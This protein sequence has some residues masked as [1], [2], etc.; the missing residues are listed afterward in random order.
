MPSRLHRSVAVPPPPSQPDELEPVFIGLEPLEPRVYADAAPF[1]VAEL[2]QPASRGGWFSMTGG[3][4]GSGAEVLPSSNWDNGHTLMGLDAMWNDPR[5]SGYH[6]TGFRTVI[7]DSG[8]NLGSSFFGPDAD[9]NGIADRIV[10]QYDFA[11]GDADASDNMGHGSNVAAAAA[12]SDPMYGGVAP[13]AGI[14]ALRV[15]NDQGQGNFTWL[16]RGLQWVVSHAAQYNIASVNLSL[17]DGNYWTQHVSMYGVGDELATLAGM[18]VVVSVAAGNGYS[19]GNSRAGLSYPAADPNVVSVGAV[20]SQPGGGF[21][22]SGGAVANSTVAGAITPFSQ[23]G[24]LL[25]VMAPGAPIVGPSTGTGLSLM[26]GTSQ[27]APQVAGLAV[28]AQQMATDL[29]GRRLTVNEFRSILVSSATSIIDGDDEDD[30]VQHNGAQYPLVNALGMAEA[31]WAMRVDAAPVEN[32]APV[33]EGIDDLAG[34]VTGRGAVLTY[35]TLLRATHAT[36]AEGDPLQFRIDSLMEGTLTINGRE[37]TAG[38][39]IRPGDSVVWTAPAGSSGQLKAFSVRVNDGATDSAESVAVCVDVQD[40]PAT[41][42]ARGLRLATD[43]P[44]A[45]VDPGANSA[46]AQSEPVRA[47]GSPQFLVWGASEV[48]TSTPST[49]N[50]AALFA[51]R[52]P[53]LAA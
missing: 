46:M 20:Y 45:S 29:L 13:D 40:R 53:R 8:I 27:A 44:L 7:L 47:L 48:F 16:E 19:S 1:P 23:R 22:Y 4:G 37:A 51:T 24:P 18:G 31:I 38:S 25:D 41:G 14:I 42:Y 11:N 5:F 21:S 6:G 52:A 17:G 15:F 43:G 2:M 26:H 32:T 50:V 12:S 30:N 9:H 10:Y 35:D 36:D 49:M 33:L 39:L 28:L 34:G 3:G